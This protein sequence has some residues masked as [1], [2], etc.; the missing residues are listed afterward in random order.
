M[1][2]FSTIAKLFASP[3]DALPGP[4]SWLNYYSNLLCGERVEVETAPDVWAAGHIK[5]VGEDVYLGEAE[6]YRAY[7]V[8]DDGSF[9]EWL[10]VENVLVVK[11]L[12]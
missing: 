9:S 6:V 12:A 10:L 1:W 4:E 3:A 2:F 11:G 5:D 7:W 8:A